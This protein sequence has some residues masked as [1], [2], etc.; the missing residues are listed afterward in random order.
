M[1]VVEQG[2]RL[3]WTRMEALEMEKEMNQFEL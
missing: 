1:T 3:A 2:L